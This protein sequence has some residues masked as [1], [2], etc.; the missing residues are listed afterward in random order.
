M[1][2]A[3]LLGL[4]AV[5]YLGLA[6]ILWNIRG[7]RRSWRGFG[8]RT[9]LTV[10]VCTL[11]SGL[12]E[13][14]IVNSSQGQD[15]HKIMGY[16]P[17]RWEVIPNGIDVER[18]QPNRNARDKIRA[19]L[20]VD[21][22]ELLIGSVARFH[23]MKG[24]E[25]LL[26]VIGRTHKQFHDLHFVLV[27]E[28]LDR[29][30]S[31]LMDWARQADRKGKLHLLGARGDVPEIMNALDVFVLPSKFGEGFP[32]VV[33]EAMSTGIACVVTDV[34]DS[35]KLA[36]DSGVVVPPGDADALENGLCTLIE[37]G[38][39]ARNRLGSMGRERI[40][41]SYGVNVMIGAYEQLYSNLLI[42][43]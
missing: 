11:L 28:G 24:L 39:E 42:P 1:Y 8:F 31:R 26:E 21:E 5:R 6:P 15:D 13:V 19:E 32:N 30:N 12:P 17:K 27:G 35:A 37:A 25:V 22:G 9:G 18:F 14:V 43:A 10:K 41:A 36:D 16:K 34:G 33:G 4:L 7:T 23:P 2:H 29:G 38:A 40:V 20:G 3:D